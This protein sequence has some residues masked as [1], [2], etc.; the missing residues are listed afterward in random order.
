MTS[1]EWEILFMT[2]GLVCFANKNK[3]C[4]LSYS[5]FQSSQ[6]GG[7][8]YSDTSPYKTA[9]RASLPERQERRFLRA[10]DTRWLAVAAQHRLSGGSSRAGRPSETRKKRLKLFFAQ[11]EVINFKQKSGKNVSFYFIIFGIGFNS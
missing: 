8:W 4:R 3:N 7:Q 11:S 6:T 10:R 5:R 2:V 1:N 9:K